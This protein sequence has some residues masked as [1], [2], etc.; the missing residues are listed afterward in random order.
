[1]GWKGLIGFLKFRKRRKNGKLFPAFQFISVTNDCNLRCQGCWVTASGNKTYM[2]PDTIHSIITAGKKQGSYFYGIL[3]G[4]PLLYKDLV[5]VFSKHPDCYFQLFTNGTLFTDDIAIRLR[6]AGNVTPLFSFEGDEQVSDIRRGGHKIFNRTIK[7][8]QLAVSHRLITG[9]AISVCKSNI[10]MALS[11]AF[12]QKLH[13]LGVIYVWYYI[14]RPTGSN[15]NYELALNANDILRLRKFLVEG[16]TRLPM[17]IIDSYWRANGEPF[18]PAA[19]GLSHHVNP[20][21]FIEPCPVI[22]L[23]GDR[24]NS[25]QLPQVYENSTFLRAFRNE[26]NHK[27]N[28]CILM[29][30]PAWIKNFAE[31]HHAQNTSNRP[32]FLNDLGN[33]PQVAS[34]GSCPVIPE[35]NLLYRLAK[36]T[37]FFGM[38]AYG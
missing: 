4:E 15:P 29:E 36:K 11:D 19:D 26:I 23:A 21:G 10:E 33:A 35:K 3:G 38:G 12:V 20:E 18:C 34:H 32:D 31:R 24:I 5:S 27:T 2:H 17:V 14:Y 9:V 16:R 8:I 22:Q 1:M 37:A 28:G 30:D 25:E 7:A 6:K 13:D